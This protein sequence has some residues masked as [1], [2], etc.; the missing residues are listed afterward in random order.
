MIWLCDLVIN[1]IEK[2]DRFMQQVDYE[3]EESEDK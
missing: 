3:F 2:V 1:D